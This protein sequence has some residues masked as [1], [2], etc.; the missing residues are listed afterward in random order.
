MNS[1]FDSLIW[2]LLLIVVG[3]LFMARNLGYDV[4]LTPTFWMS[5][6]GTLSALSFIRYFAGDL[7]RWGRLFPASQFAA[8]AVMIG[9]SQADVQ[10]SIVGT[11]LFIGFAIPF[12]VAVIVDY[13]QNYWAVIPATIFAVLT[14]TA[15]IGNRATGELLG[16]LAAFVVAAPFFFVY[17]TQEKQWWAIMPAGILSSIGLT[18]LLVALDPALEY[19]NVKGALISLGFAATFG[20]LYLRRSTINTAWAKYPTIVFGFIA[21]LALVD[22]TRIDGGPLVLIVLGLLLLY[23]SVRPRRHLVS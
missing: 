20:M 17:F 7:K 18:A 2:G 4:D 14:V 19:S 1:K 3:G 6:C 11:P 13:R 23:S 5:V 22:N 9:L 21:L 16:G 15:L 12:T 8:I 10:G